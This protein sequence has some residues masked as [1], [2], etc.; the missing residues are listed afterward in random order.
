MGDFAL[1][2]ETVK[3]A[4]AAGYARQ[5][6]QRGARK[7]RLGGHDVDFGGTRAEGESKR[8]GIAVGLKLDAGSKRYPLA[9]FWFQ[10]EPARNGCGP[11][12]YA[13]WPAYLEG[14]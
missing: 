10:I 13:C 12:S 9:R 1:A 14:H 2:A 6:A 7:T 4:M 8:L 5:A 11:A 3:A